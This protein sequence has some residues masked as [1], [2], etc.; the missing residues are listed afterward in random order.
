MDNSRISSSTLGLIWWLMGAGRDKGSQ[1]RNKSRWL[2][3][4]IKSTHSRRSISTENRLMSQGSTMAS[5]PPSS[6]LSLSFIDYIRS[7]TRWVRREPRWSSRNAAK[8]CSLK[9]TKS[10]IVRE[11]PRKTSICPSM[12]RFGCGLSSSESY[13]RISVWGCLSERKPSMIACIKHELRAA[14]QNRIQLYSLS[15]EIVGLLPERS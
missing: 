4:S 9:S 6:C 3:C 7:S 15:R 11:T 14:L 2:W 5:S 1:T 8:S 12:A 13:V 10:S